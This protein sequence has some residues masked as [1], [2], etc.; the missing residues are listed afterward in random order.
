MK[1]QLLLIVFCIISLPIWAQQKAN[2]GFVSFLTYVKITAEQ[3][4]AECSDDKVTNKVEIIKAYN[5]LRV[6]HEQLM[7]QLIADIKLKNSLKLYKELDQIYKGDNTVTS[8]YKSLFDDVDAKLKAI[9]KPDRNK[10]ITELAVGDIT[11]IATLV[12][13]IIKDIQENHQK[14][15]DGIC[16]ILNNLRLNSPIELTKK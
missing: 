5:E 8:H 14:K 6:L 4:V 7:V 2:L 3:K 12:Y 9:P 13:G 1:N 15:V 16:E 10:R 11:D